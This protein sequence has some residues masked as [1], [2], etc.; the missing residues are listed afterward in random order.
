LEVIVTIRRSVVVLACA[1]A[2]FSAACGDDNTGSTDTSTDTSTD[3]SGGGSGAVTVSAANFA[4]SPASIPVEAGADVELTF[5]NDDTTQHSFTADDLG[6]DLVLDGGDSDTTTFT[7]PDSG[8]VEFH[9]KFHEA[10]T[11]TITTDG[12]ATGSGGGSG[13][14]DDLDY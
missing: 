12:S 9:C 6:V 2:L 1:L 11:G 5:T 14:S 3:E 10:M 13:E 7:A 4:F 8:S